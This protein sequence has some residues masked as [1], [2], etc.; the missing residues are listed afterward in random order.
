MSDPEP[1]SPATPFVRRLVALGPHRGSHRV[2]MRA[3]V[4]VLVPLLVLVL[5]G[6]EEWTAYAAFGAFTS[7]YGRNHARAERTGMQAVAGGFLTLAVTLGVVVSLLPDS[8]WIVVPVGAL[9]AAGG[10]L[11]S[12]AY[13]WHPPGPLFLVFGFAVSAVVPATAATVPVA[14]AIAAASALFSMLVAQLGVLREPASWSPPLLPAPRF[15]DALA[16]RGAVTHLVRHVLALTVAGGIATALDWQHPYWAMVAAVVVLSGPDLLSRLTRGV[17]RVVGTLLGLG[18]AALV[19]PWHP[20]GVAAVLVIVALQVLTELFV[21]RNYAV[22]LLF[23]T[24]L[25]LL[26]GQLAH[27]APIGPLLRDR[28]LETVLGAVVGAVVLLAVPDRLEPELDPEL[29]A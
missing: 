11:T 19:L 21:G 12:D 1:R 2:A 23:I 24:P 3:G 27:E 5:L 6:R 8:R 16:P 25:A 9:L 18:V 15:R 10:S 29:D 28:L 13:G 4:S 22:A 26:M 17:Q 7:L 14:A 20:Q